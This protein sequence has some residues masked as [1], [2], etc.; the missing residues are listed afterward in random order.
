MS[1]ETVPISVEYYISTTSD[2]TTF[3]IIEGGSWSNMDVKPVRGFDRLRHK[4]VYNEKEI[5]I[6]KPQNDRT[7]VEARARCTLNI[8]KKYLDSY[9]SYLISKG[10]LPSTSVRIIINGKEMHK[11]E[12]P[13]NIY[14]D[15]DNLVLF[16]LLANLHVSA[17]QK[18]ERKIVPEKKTEAPKKKTETNPIVV[19]FHKDF[20]EVFE[21]TKPEKEDVEEVFKWLR[22]H[23]GNA[24]RFLDIEVCEKLTYETE[25]HF[26]KF[27]NLKKNVSSES[28]KTLEEIAKRHDK[29]RETYGKQGSPIGSIRTKL[30]E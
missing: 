22:S 23:G 3:Q 28:K 4:I 1:I 30:S 26:M 24:R 5:A 21:K 8:D 12:H 16:Y 10:D 19:H 29:L 13:Y 25:T 15:P 14:R 17:F 20:D 11:M 7:L 2:W 18:Q 27:P 6:S 9:I